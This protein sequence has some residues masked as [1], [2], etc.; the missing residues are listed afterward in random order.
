MTYS[1]KVSVIIP[2]Y[3]RPETLSRAIDSVLNQTYSNIEIIVVDDN[4][5]VSIERTLTERV[6]SYYEKKASVIYIKHEKNRNGSA[7]RNTGL[8]N[9]SGAYITFLD[10]D[11]EFLPSKIESQVNCLEARDFSW[12]AC[13]TKYVSKSGDKVVNILTDKKEGN[14]LLDALMRNLFLAAGSNLFIRR[15]VVD[16]IGG[17]NENF[18]R[19][20]DL[21][22]L[23]RVLEKYKLAYVD[24]LGVIIYIHP[25]SA[26]VDY[27]KVTDV[28]LKTF[29]SHINRLSSTDHEKLSKM[30]N[31]QLFRYYF[32]QR[33]DI[34]ATINFAFKNRISIWSISRYMFHL[35]DRML[36]KKACGY[37]L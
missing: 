28:F 31:L 17:F 30:I 7:A 21:E 35:F 22:F 15:E 27:Q 24:V 29:S 8:K 16:D 5:P 6:L 25:L 1:P 13:Y 36:K 10:D 23:V 20:Q 4:D 12:G 34:K 33:K 2:T 3:K 18:S 26:L 32:L 37:S 9:S 14:L 11:D 19:N